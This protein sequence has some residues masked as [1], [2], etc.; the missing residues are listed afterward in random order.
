[1]RGTAGAVGANRADR[2]IRR[3]AFVYPDRG[4]LTAAHWSG[5]PAALLAAFRGHGVDVHEVG[6]DLPRALTAPVHLLASIGARGTAEADHHRLKVRARESAMNASLRALG[7][8]D[9]VVAVGTDA[10]RLGRL[11]VRGARTATYDDAT[12]QTMWDHPDSDTRAAGFRESAVRRWIDV[13]RASVRAATVACVSTGWAATSFR[14]GYGVPDHRVRVVGMGHRSRVPHPGVRRAPHPAFL[15]VGVDWK[16]KNGAAVLRGF[17]RVR[18]R[19]P[20]AVLHLVG[21]HTAVRQPGV[22]DHGLLRRDDVDAQRLLDRLYLSCTAFVL[23]S[24]FDPS[25]IAYLEAASAGLPV[26]ATREGGAGELLREGAITVDPSAD[27][28]IARAMMTLAD[29]AEAARRGALAARAA[30]TA[31]W[32]HVAGRILDA[33]EAA[34]PPGAVSSVRGHSAHLVGDDPRQPR[35]GRLPAHRGDAR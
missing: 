26:I 13:Q 27:E 21:E 16:R 12:L 24:R 17:A 6:Y 31:T 10:Y 4:P 9:A 23:P 19:F 32:H 2:S 14:D 22:L 20:D 15:F 30:R 7:H 1:M 25:P 28:E 5:T 35:A 3:L 11:D 34:D 18:E 8:I 33:L 29:S